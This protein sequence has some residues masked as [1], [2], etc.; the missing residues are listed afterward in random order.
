MIECK[1][2]TIDEFSEKLKAKS[3]AFCIECYNILERKVGALFPT[4]RPASKTHLLILMWIKVAN[5]MEFMESQSLAKAPL[6]TRHK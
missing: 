1:S 5:S 4:D 6:N 3:D 2:S